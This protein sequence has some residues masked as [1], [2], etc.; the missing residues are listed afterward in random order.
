MCL[1]VGVALGKE[2]VSDATTISKFRRLM[3]KNNLLMMSVQPIVTSQKS[4]P[5]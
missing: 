5:G 2:Q 1:F 4:E 3:E